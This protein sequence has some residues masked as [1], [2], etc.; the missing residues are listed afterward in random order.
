VDRLRP[1]AW[2]GAAN[3]PLADVDTDALQQHPDAAEPEFLEADSFLAGPSAG[4][5]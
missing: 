4:A 5:P 3:A 1:R 2:I